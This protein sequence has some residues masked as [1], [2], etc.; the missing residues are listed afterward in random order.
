MTNSELAGS[1]VNLVGGKSNIQGCFHCITRLRFTL[2][3][4]KEVEPEAIKALEGVAGVVE[5]GGM[6]MVIIGPHVPKVYAEV[7]KIIGKKE[8]ALT[9]PE[10]QNKQNLFN[11]LLTY[12]C[13]SYKPLFGLMAGS[14]LIKGLLSI[15]VVFLPAFKEGNTYAVLYGMADAILYFMPVFVAA[16]AAKYMKID[17]FLGG[18]IGAV[19][20]CPN[21]IGLASQEATWSLF[22]MNMVVTK[23]F[24]IIPL[25]ALNYTSSLFPALVAIGIAA[26]VYRWC[27]KKIPD[28]LQMFVTPF[29][30]LLVAVLITLLVF[31]PVVSVISALIGWLLAAIYN[32][33]PWLCGLAV[34]GP[35]IIMVMMGL[36]T[37]FIP[38]LL[39]EIMT[40]GS[41]V[42]LGFLGANQMAMTGA[43]VAVFVKTRSK[44]GKSLSG[45]TGLSCFLGISEPGLYGV[46]IPSKVGLIWSV[47]GGSLG[48]MIA[49]IMGARLYST[50]ISG[51]LQI[52]LA[53]NA[54]NMVGF[55]GY[56][57]SL[58]IG[59]AVAFIGTYMTY[60]N[61]TDSIFESA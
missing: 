13:A 12:I 18:L 20:I 39:N 27:K 50:G 49:A 52:T 8:E 56:C 34:G 26:P 46:L 1:I 42:I 60:N 17:T 53:I 2:H 23:I 9:N 3:S 29:I 40:N 25:V 21:I 38:V 14:G 58:V 55:A 30:T 6:F 15:M 43:L 4:S 41:S 32:F 35:W 22:G 59:F 5:K 54:D 48:G 37:G 57:I 44:K 47:I 7:E 11:R 16:G 31:G 19:L 28:I 10:Q 61:K 24:G 33:S 45:S 51:I 36:H